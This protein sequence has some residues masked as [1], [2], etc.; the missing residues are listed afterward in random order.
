MGIDADQLLKDMVSDA[1]VKKVQDAKANADAIG[2]SG[3]PTLLFNGYAW[4]A[5]QRGT[6]IFSIYTDLYLNKDK[7]FDACPAMAIDQSKSYSATITTTKGDIVVDLFDDQ[8]PF[9]VN[10][11]VFLAREGWYNNMPVISTDQFA[12]SGDPT[13]TGY[14]GPGYAFKD[15]ID[16][17][18]NFNEPGMLALYAYSIGSGTNGSTFFINKI[19]LPDQTGRTI[20]G[21]VT[22]GLDV[23]NQLESRNNIFSPILDQIL[24]VTITEK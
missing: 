18:L 20:F 1:V 6:E 17:S 10:S 19:S 13:D 14:G 2:I 16:S 3:T 7:E 4:P 11:F 15:E 8:A 5:N 12:L 23:L 22:A 21:K 9:A 24:S